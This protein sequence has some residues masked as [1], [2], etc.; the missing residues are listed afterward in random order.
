MTGDHSRMAHH[1][2]ERELKYLVPAG[3]SVDP[4]EVVAALTRCGFVQTER[5]TKCKREE[6]FDD[7]VLSCLRRGDVLRRTRHVSARGVD[8]HYMYKRNVTDPTKPYVSKVELGSGNFQS[9]H[10]FAAALGM[11]EER[12]LDIVLCAVVERENAVVQREGLRLLIC[13]DRVDYHLPGSRTAVSDAM[14]EIEDWTRPNEYYSEA[15]DDAHLL[16][17]DDAVLLELGA[18]LRRTALSKYARGAGLLRVPAAGEAPDPRP[19]KPRHRAG[20]HRSGRH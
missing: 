3:S 2:L 7:G 14:V 10:D 9:V 8:V 13:V 11:P 17:A 6:Y 20:Y 16:A 12:D 19:S 1:N 15:F 5:M 18:W 4:S